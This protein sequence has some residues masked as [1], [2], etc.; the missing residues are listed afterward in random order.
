M[1]QDVGLAPKAELQKAQLA[2]KIGSLTVTQLEASTE[3]SGQKA[4]Q[5][6]PVRC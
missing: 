5:R 3:E 4:R 2:S 6:E 1:A